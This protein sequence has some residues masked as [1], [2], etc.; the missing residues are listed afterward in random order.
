[1]RL[2]APD[3]VDLSSALLPARST[4]QDSRM[5]I[6][7]RVVGIESVDDSEKRNSRATLRLDDE[8]DSIFLDVTAVIANDA[9][10]TTYCHSRFG[11]VS[12]VKLYRV[13]E[14]TGENEYTTRIVDSDT[15]EALINAGATVRGSCKRECPELCLHKPCF[16]DFSYDKRST[17]C[18]CNLDATSSCAVDQICA[19]LTDGTEQC[20][21]AS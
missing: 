15:R 8:T 1:M 11:F 10:G 19:V 20:E 3:F 4:A 6:D 9:E 12:E 5:C 21:D 14:Q 13:C 7:T 17:V 18:T 2:E 16:D